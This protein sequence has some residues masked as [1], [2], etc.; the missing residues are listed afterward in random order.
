[1]ETLA[2]AFTDGV[3]SFLSSNH[4]AG[5]FNGVPLAFESASA[6]AEGTSVV[7]SGGVA[8]RMGVVQTI[9]LDGENSYYTTTVTLTNL[10]D[11]AMTDIRYMRNN[12]P[13]HDVDSGGS[14]NT[15]NDVLSNP[16]AGSIAAVNAQGVFG[17]QNL[18]LLADQ[19]A[20]NA[21]NNLAADTI[22]VRTSAFGFE[23]TNPFAVQAFDNPADPNG[24]S[25]DIG[26]NIVFAID[27]LAA[28]Q[29]VTFSWITS[30][31]GTTGGGDVIMALTGQ[32]TLDGGAGDDRIYASQ[33]AVEETLI[34]GAG[35]DILVGLGTAAGSGD[36]LLGGEGLD[37]LIG[38]DGR[39]VLAGGLGAD[40]FVYDDAD[41]LFTVAGNTSYATAG[42]TP[43]TVTDFVSGTD[44]LR[45]LQ[46]AFAGMALGSLTN[47]IG[48]SVI[49]GSYDGSNA[50]VNL[51][52]GLGQ[53]S[54]IYSQSDHTLFFDSN[55]SGAGYQA[56]ADID[57]M[58][59]G[60]I[61]VV[62]HA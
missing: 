58:A 54:F 51:N 42:G 20:L 2:L 47:G 48:F 14:F 19:A 37:T 16:G 50:G 21:A 36:V 56:V 31:N 44:S 26:I 12:D 60:D 30:A 6:G 15:L 11:D 43:D 35:D 52:H 55:G 29:S 53:A 49:A 25:G 23:N 40:S 17:G 62:A 39:D 57:Q 59:A 13:D 10:G 4:N 34:G 45:F 18:M 1:M 32:T 61:Q 9:T 27:S 38:S 24:A 3:G 33:A 46:A 8:E 7:S 22:E 28:G 41:G 5:G